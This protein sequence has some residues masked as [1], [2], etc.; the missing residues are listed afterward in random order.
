MNKLN[1]SGFTLIELM[2]TVAVIAIVL[3]IAV[4]SFQQVIMTNRMA[5]QAND[6]LGSMN[7]ARSEAVKRGQRVVLCETADPF[8]ATP[9]C[10]TSGAWEQGWLIF[11]DSNNDALATGEVLLKVHESISPST[12]SGD[13]DVANYL[14]YA[15]DGTTRLTDNTF[16]SGTLTLCP[17][18]SGMTGRSIAVN[19][20]GRARIDSVTC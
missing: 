9:A 7:L 2:V 13:T 1:A 20:A 10:T 12:L 3:T 5:T 8:A 15:A 17:G 11:V 6:L 16:Q 4:P 14:S 18:T 19:A